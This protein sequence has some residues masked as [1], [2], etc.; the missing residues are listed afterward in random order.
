VVQH[1]HL[2]YFAL[3]LSL[4][5]GSTSALLCQSGDVTSRRSS[6]IHDSCHRCRR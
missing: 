2:D 1:S 4:C 6:F 3:S 5:A